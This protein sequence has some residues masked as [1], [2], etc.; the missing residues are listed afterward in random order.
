MLKDD[1]QGSI[2][3]VYPDSPGYKREGTSQEA[4]EAIKSRAKRL[5]SMVLEELTRAPGTA[6]EIAQRL[7]EDRLSIRPRLSELAAKN[8]IVDSGTRRVNES[9]KSATVW[10]RS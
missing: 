5:C 2:F 6:D 4:A 10:R 3:D 1:R 8:L 9:G 7:G